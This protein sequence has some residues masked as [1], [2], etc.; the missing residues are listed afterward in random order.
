MI[1]L[2]KQP[3][4]IKMESLQ[5]KIEKLEK[6]LALYEKD[7]P[8]RAYYVGQRMLN[9]QLDIIDEFKLKDEIIKNPKED[10]LYDRVM[11]LFGD[12]TANAT[13]INNLKGELDLSGDEKKD[14]SRKPSFLDKM[15]N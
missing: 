14:I 3:K 10:K 11:S 12:L 15:A 4:Y 7:S 1:I 8:A 9:Q 2:K 13:K 5:E 6:K